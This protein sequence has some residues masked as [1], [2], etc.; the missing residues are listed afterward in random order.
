[1][2]CSVKKPAIRDCTRDNIRMPE[3]IRA[4]CRLV[5]TVVPGKFRKYLPAAASLVYFQGK[6]RNNGTAG[7][8]AS[9]GNTDKSSSSQTMRCLFYQFIYNSSGGHIFLKGST[10]RSCYVTFL[11]S[12]SSNALFSSSQPSSTKRP[13]R[14]ITYSC[15][16][17]STAVSSPSSS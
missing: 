12:P 9:N 17:P 4:R 7:I 15:P 10:I 8:A 14:I 3:G 16:P 6:G 5:P 1:M 2:K 13:S 11:Y